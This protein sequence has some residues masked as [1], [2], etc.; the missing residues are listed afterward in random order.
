M[1]QYFIII[2]N[3]QA[4]PYAK[5]QLL[6]A[7][8]T[9]NTPVWRQGMAD[10]APA[11]SLTELSD[12]FYCESGQSF[13]QPEQ[14]YSTRPPYEEPPYGQ[15]A[16]GQ[17]PYGQQPPYGQQNPYGQ[18]P[19]YGPATHTNWMPWAIVGTIIG[20]LFSCIGLIFGIIGINAAGKANN[21]YAAG[22]Y[23]TGDANNSTAKTMTIIALVLGGLGLLAN[24]TILSSLPAIMGMGALY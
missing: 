21:A 17:Q 15:R 5:E 7:G 13:S 22:D 1:H 20:G 11:S 9:A 3:S 14:S 2:G 24:I 23:A 6:G 8:L 12:L 18:Q 10:W 4:G 19:P 16:Y